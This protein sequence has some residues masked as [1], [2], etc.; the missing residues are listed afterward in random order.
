MRPTTLFLLLSFI[1]FSITKLNAQV[2]NEIT[3]PTLTK[4]SLAEK[5]YLQIDNVLYQA[6]E[7][8]WF[9]AIVAKSYDNSLSDLSQV[10]H[11]DLIDEEQNI[12]QN[13]L[14]KLKKGIANGSFIIEESYKPGKYHI[15]AYTN[16]NRNFDEDF[17]FLQPVDIINLREDI[18]DQKP[19]SNIV[20]STGESKRVKADINPGIVNPSFKGKLMLYLDA[21]K[22]LD[23]VMLENTNDDIYKLDYL[24][25]EDTRQI[26]LKFKTK[27]KNTFNKEEEHFYS[28]TIVLDKNQIDLQFFPEGGKLVNGLLSTIGFKGIDANGLGKKISGIVKDNKGNTITSFSSNDLGMGTFK[29]LPK[30]GKNYYAEV[31]ENQIDYRYNLPIAKATGSVLSLVGLKDDINLLIA[32]NNKSSN[33][34][35]V[36]TQARGVKYHSFVFKHRDTIISSIPKESLPNGVIKVS[37]LDENKQV[38]CERL[39]F[40]NREDHILDIKLAS[41]KAS[42]MQRDKVSLNLS[43]DTRQNLNNINLSVLVIDNERNEASRKH[44]SHIMSYLLL[45]SELKGLIENP[46]YY[47]D[48]TNRDRAMDLN[49]LMLT[50]GWRDYKYQKSPAGVTYSYNPEKN[51]VVSGTVGEYLNPK[52]RPK[53]PLDINLFVYGN[54]AA[55]YSQE[56]NYNGK[57]NFELDDI[58]KAKTEIFMQVVNKKGEP[59]DF[60]INLDKKWSPSL[61]LQKN[62]HKVELPE[63]VISAFTEKI[64]TEN[65]VQQ[66][67][68]T[69]YNTIALEEV[70]IKGYKL[71]PKR[72][73]FI[74]LHGE[75]DT[76]IEGKELIEKAPDW[77]YGI[78]SVLM[79]KYPNEVMVID[80]GPRNDPFLR[81]VVRGTERP[82]GFTYILVDNIPIQIRDYRL[83][84]HIPVDQVESIDIL[85]NPKNRN[86]YCQEVLS[87][88]FC[89]PFSV[90][91]I[92]IYTHSGNGLHGI[93]KT[94]GHL[95]NNINGFTE[96]AEFY[97]PNY[98]TISSQD[99]VIPDNRSVIHWEPNIT[100]NDKGEY[101]IEF[102]NDDHIGE[103]SVIVEAISEDGKI[104][105]VKKSYNVEEAGR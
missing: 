69:Q 32:S 21:G 81:A 15:R 98:E 87:G 34:I 11:V 102:Y 9:K 57:Y 80:E 23:S 70:N 45:N 41:E 19:I 96:S 10:L 105:Y 40:N 17:T 61:G 48:I 91:L 62:N 104:G 66:E 54:P 36:E 31:N 33:T 94:K 51:I 8:I 77:N 29:L 1:C 85:R 84:G 90:A 79:A 68:E 55:V 59:V 47:F 76:V 65:K 16:W 4:N 28:K 101:V 75:P 99:W 20:L 82:G 78:F 52:K 43:L 38:I 56:I 95:V 13:Q 12:I 100:L 93:V 83:V 73:E 26:D 18:Q 97:A 64:E 86:E 6:G 30:A 63:R 72:E 88:P 14:L 27:S 39:F 74:A 60:N 3:K 35:K 67:Y 71:T 24:L 22:Y 92:N 46:S 53:K 89:P 42:Y 49:S 44:K 103:V 5:I 50:Q 58:Y 25:P 7:T 2:F 37:V